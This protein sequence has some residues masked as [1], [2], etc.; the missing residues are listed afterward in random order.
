MAHL[1]N[2][3]GHFIFT[4]PRRGIKSYIQKMFDNQ[5]IPGLDCLTFKLLAQRV[6]NHD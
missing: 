2:Q 4:G 3:V 5:T 1:E 6:L